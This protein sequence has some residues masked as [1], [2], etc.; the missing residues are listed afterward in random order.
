M[1]SFQLPK[2]SPP[3]QGGLE[4]PFKQFVKAL[5]KGVLDTPRDEDVVG[6]HHHRA[7][8]SKGRVHMLLTERKEVTKRPPKSIAKAELL[9]WKRLWGDLFGHAVQDLCSKR[10]L[11]RQ[12][13]HLSSEASLY[14]FLSCLCRLF[15][16]R[17]RR[18]RRHQL[19]IG[20]AGTGESLRSRVLLVKYNLFSLSMSTLL[21]Y[22]LYAITTVLKKYIIKLDLPLYLEFYK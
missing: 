4:A 3:S 17:K 9:C 16:L 18:W 2:A 7:L 20:A 12:N 11:V 10:H 21:F 15:G 22:S 14:V 6:Q 5:L 13:A 8:R 1:E 19:I